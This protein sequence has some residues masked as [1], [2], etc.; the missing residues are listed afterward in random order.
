M[1][2]NSNG[3]ARKGAGRKSTEKVE[4]R[5][6][7]MKQILPD[8]EFWTIVASQCRQADMKAVDIWAKYRFGTPTQIIDHYSGG[9]PIN[10]PLVRWVQEDGD[11]Q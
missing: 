6:E 5:L 3:G 1:G 8:D 9:K 11:Q 4:E 7:V 10:I 2:K